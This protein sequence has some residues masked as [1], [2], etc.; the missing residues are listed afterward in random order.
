MRDVAIVGGPGECRPLVIWPPTAGRSP[1][2]G[3]RSHRHSGSLQACSPKSRV[4]EPARAILNPLSTVRFFAPAGVSFGSP[5]PIPK[6]S[7]SIE[8]SSIRAGTARRAAGAE[9]AVAAASPRST[10]PSIA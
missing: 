6:P 1:F 8:K 2:R 7:S 3:T 5:L 10:P 4:D 9:I